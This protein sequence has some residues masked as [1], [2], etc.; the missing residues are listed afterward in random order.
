MDKTVFTQKKQNPDR[1]IL[2][3]GIV[4]LCLFAVVIALVLRNSN[5][6]KNKNLNEIS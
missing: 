3:L 2:L 6:I 4:L 5:L 1:N